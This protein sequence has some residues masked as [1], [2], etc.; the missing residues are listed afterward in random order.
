MLDLTELP[1]RKH[2][3]KPQAV[4]VAQPLEL[5]GNN[6]AKRRPDAAAAKMVLGQSADPE[7]D[8][9]DRAVERLQIGRQLAI[10]RDLAK[11]RY[12]GQVIRGSHA[13]VVGQAIV[14]A[15]LDVQA[16]QV[17]PARPR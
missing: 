1:A 9:I 15:A 13:V 6:R 12:L 10:G 14:A 3:L 8:V 2:S 7:I 11:A 4:A 5:V 16:R 17:K